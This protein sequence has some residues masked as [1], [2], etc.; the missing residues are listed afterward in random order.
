[1][2]KTKRSVR[3]SAQL[4]GRVKRADLTRLLKSAQLEGVKLVEFFPIG[5]PAPDG[6][7]GVWHVRPG[8]VGA[9]LEAILKNRVT[10]GVTVFPKGIPRPDLFEVTFEVG[11]A[12]T[13]AH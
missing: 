1:M 13:P 11:S 3:G 12:R 7:W 10:P 2:A 8:R 5:I 4:A 9:L 6:G